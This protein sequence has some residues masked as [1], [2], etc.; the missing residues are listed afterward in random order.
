[1]R[2]DLVGL[3][4]NLKHKIRPKVRRGDAG[5]YMCT[6]SNNVGTMSA[7]EIDLRI[8]CKPFLFSWYRINL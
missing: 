6:A 1:V 4:E 5:T 7:D 3:R 8:L 2:E